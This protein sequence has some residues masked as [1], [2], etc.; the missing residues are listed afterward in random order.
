MDSDSLQSIPGACDSP[1]R[2]VSDPRIIQDAVWA[3]LVWAGLN[4]TDQDLSKP[5]DPKPAET[6]TLPGQPCPGSGLDVALCGA[7]TRRNCPASCRLHPLG[8]WGERIERATVCFLH[9]PVNKTGTAFSKPIDGVVRCAVQL[10]EQDAPA[11]TILT[12]S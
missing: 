4:L 12:R 5:G 3:K 2:Q 6:V 11:S 1:L 9:V 8:Q 10:W 7:A